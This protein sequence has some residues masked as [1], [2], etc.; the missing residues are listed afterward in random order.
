MHN[1]RMTVINTD[2][3]SPKSHEPCSPKEER[4]RDDSLTV[5]EIGLLDLVLLEAIIENDFRCR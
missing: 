5:D 3:S 2:G 4:A 1:R